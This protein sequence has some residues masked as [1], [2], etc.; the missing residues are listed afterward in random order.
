MKISNRFQYPGQK[1]RLIIHLND[2][3]NGLSLCCLVKRKN[4][5]FILVKELR[6]IPTLSVASCTD[7]ILPESISL[8]AST[9]FSSTSGTAFSFKNIILH[10]VFHG[11]EYLLVARFNRFSFV[12]RIH[13]V[14]LGLTSVLM[15]K[16]ITQRGRQSNLFSRTF[17]YFCFL[18][19]KFLIFRTCGFRLHDFCQNCWYVPLICRNGRRHLRRFHYWSGFSDA[20]PSG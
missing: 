9:T 3:R 13:S 4:I 16:I 17:L 8:F 14:C 2:H 10:F 18:F 5:I 11:N 1:S 15:R 19:T 20:S 12:Y 6:L 7:A